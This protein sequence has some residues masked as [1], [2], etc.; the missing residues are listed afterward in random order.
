MNQIY[1]VALTIGG[2]TEDAALANGKGPE[3]ELNPRSWRLNEESRPKGFSSVTSRPLLN[4]SHVLIR[5]NRSV[6]RT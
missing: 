4:F 3:S 5:T 1:G 2:I 6:E